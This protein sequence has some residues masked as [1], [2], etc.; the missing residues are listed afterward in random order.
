M[1]YG[2]SP[3]IYGE[4]LMLSYQQLDL[5]LLLH[6]LLPYPAITFDGTCQ[7]E[8]PAPPSCFCLQACQQSL[9]SASHMTWKHCSGHLASNSSNSLQVVANKRALANDECS[10]ATSLQPSS[11][12]KS[13]EHETEKRNKS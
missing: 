4:Q 8:V 9:Q 7:H 13:C 10:H 3:A 6:L 2:E 1:I 5:P 11:G 12:Y